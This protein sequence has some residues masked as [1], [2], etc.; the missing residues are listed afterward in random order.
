MGPGAQAWRS[1]RKESDSL[2]VV[3]V[4]ADKLWGAQTQRPLEYFSIGQD[5]MPRDDYF[6]WVLNKAAA[7][8]NHDGGRLDDQRYELIV[9]MREFP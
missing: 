8:A 5:L 2:G 9:Q 1:T 7:I 4:P 3:E 6:L